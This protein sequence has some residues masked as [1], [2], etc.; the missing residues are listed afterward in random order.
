MKNRAKI[1]PFTTL[2]RAITG[3]LPTLQNIFHETL[4]TSATFASFPTCPKHDH[5]ITQQWLKHIQSMSNACPTHGPNM[6]NPCPTHVHHM[7]NSC[8][9]H[10]NIR[11]NWDHLCLNLDYFSSQA[12]GCHSY[13]CIDGHEA[14]PKKFVTFFTAVVIGWKLSTNA[15]NHIRFR[16]ESLLQ[17]S[18]ATE[19]VFLV[20]TTCPNRYEKKSESVFS[21][22]SEA[23]SLLLLLFLRAVANA[24]TPL[25][26]PFKQATQRFW[27]TRFLFRLLMFFDC[28]TYKKGVQVRVLRFLSIIILRKAMFMKCVVCFVNVQLIGVMLQQV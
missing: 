5:N 1:R 25:D 27:N 11:S 7:S 14:P 16:S 22:S 6:N 20:P 9:K 2:Q 24:P 15:Q 18:P 4:K 28:P 10:V 8:R 19:S 23:T 3:Q 21:F 12:K 26:S 13:Y 17:R